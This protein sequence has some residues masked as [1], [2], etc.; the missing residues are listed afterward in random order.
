MATFI[1]LVKKQLGRM[2]EG[3]KEEWI[4]DQAELVKEEKQQDFLMSLSGEKKI[5][6]MPTWRE[7]EE[8]CEKVENGM[9]YLE[10]ETHY[11]EFDDNGRY[12]DD[13]KIWHNDPMEAMPFLN[14]S[15][16]GCHDLLSLGEYKMVTDI[17]NRVCHLEFAVVEAEESEDFEDDS[18]F[19]IVDAYEEGILSVDIRQI[20][21]DWIRAVVR[22]TDKWDGRELAKI[23]IGIFEQS[24]CKKIN[25]TILL[26]EDLPEDL[27]LHMLNILSEEISSAEILFKETFSGIRYSHE[28]YEFEKKLKRKQKIAL[29]IRLKCMKPTQKELKTNASVLEASWK[30]IKELLDQLRYERYIDD[31][32]EIEEVWKI[33]NSLIK[34]GGVEKED[35]ELRKNILSDI[36]NNGYYDYYGCYDPLFELSEKFCTEPEEFLTLADMLDGSGC[37]R[38]RAAHLYHQ[39]GRDDKYVSYLETHLNKESKIYIEL[40]EYY[41]EQ[42]NFEKARQVAE[43]GLEKCRDKLTELYIYLLID[44]EKCRD[45]NRYKKLYSSA[46]RRRGADIVRIDDILKNKAER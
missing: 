28:K 18:P 26:G 42:G 46:K 38:E 27:F 23:L 8:F 11:Y 41:K 44:A 29:N 39:F 33:C 14:R 34:K 22:L 21:T 6:Y 43:Q 25:P 7:I 5:Q 35:W 24:I 20:A 9:I 4:L 12:M 30:Q 2:S 40:M 45:N 19:T 36:V 13:W 1:E 32:W 31:Q 17:L 3:K 37:N 15:F 10:Y 16:R